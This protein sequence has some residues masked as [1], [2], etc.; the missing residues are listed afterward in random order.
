MKRTSG[1]I[2]YDHFQTHDSPTLT[3]TLVRALFPARRWRRRSERS[4]NN[5]TET[6]DTPEG[7]SPI[8]REQMVL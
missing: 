2:F 4:M 8:G 7:S 5:L 1:A 6:A 3:A